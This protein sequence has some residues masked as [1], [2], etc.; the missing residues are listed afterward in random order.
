MLI[1]LS[2]LVVFMLMGVTFLVVSSQYQRGATELAKVDRLGNDPQNDLD[3]AMYQ[4]VRD[5]PVPPGPAAAVPGV[6]PSSLK[7]HSLLADLYGTYDGFQGIT[8]A[9]AV[10]DGNGQWFR[11]KFLP[12]TPPVNWPRQISVVPDAYN[13]CVI[14]FTSGPL[15]QYS[16]RI[17]KYSP[18]PVNEITVEAFEEPEL[19]ATNVLS[20]LNSQ[21]MEFVVN[22]FPFN[23]T[24]MGYKVSPQKNLSATYNSA[25][26]AQY[27]TLLPHVA[28]YT[29]PALPNLGGEDE[30]WDAVDV[31]NLHLAMVPPSTTIAGLRAFDIIP[32]FHRP[33]LVQ[34]YNRL[35]T[36]NPALMFGSPPLITG[37]DPTNPRVVNPSSFT[38]TAFEGRDLWRNV[39]LRPNQMDHPRFTGSNPAFGPLAL[40]PD[41]TQPTYMNFL[42]SIQYDVDN[43][44]DGIT[45]SVWLDLGYPAMTA[46]NGRKYKPLFAILC[47]D[48]DGRVNLN[49]AGSSGN[50]TTNQ[51]I[52]LTVAPAPRVAGGQPNAGVADVIQGEGYGEAEVQMGPHATIGSIPG[53]FTQVE[54]QSILNARYGDGGPGSGT[55][56]DD[57]PTTGVKPVNLGLGGTYTT[58]YV[59]NGANGIY[60]RPSDLHGR[61]ATLLDLAGQPLTFFSGTTAT[62]FNMSLLGYNPSPLN[63]GYNDPYELNLL[64][65]PASDATFG[66]VEL[67]RMLRWQDADALSLPSRLATLASL[68]AATPLA[69]NNRRRIT[70]RS[71][72][73]PAPNIVLPKKMN[74]GGNGGVMPSEL[75]YQRL[76]LSPTYAQIA[77]PARVAA[78]LR[79]MMPFEMRRGEKLNIN[80]LLGDGLDDPNAANQNGVIDEIGEATPA[81]YELTNTAPFVPAVAPYRQLLAR[82]LYCLAMLLKDPNFV[83]IDGDTNTD[84]RIVTARYIAQWAINVVDFRDSDVTMTPFEFDADPFNA[85]GWNEAIDGDPSTDDTTAPDRQIVWGCEQP[86]LLLTEAVAGHDRRTEDLDTEGDDDDAAGSPTSTTDP[87]NPDVDFDSRLR[88]HGFAFVEI[89]NPRNAITALPTELYQNDTN[90]NPALALNRIGPGGSP[91]WRMIVVKGDSQQKDPDNRQGA[92]PF[93]AT[94]IERSV[95][96]TATAPAAV[97]DHGVP[98]VVPTANIAPIPPGRY[99]VV[100]GYRRIEGGNSYV[101]T[102]GRH[103][104]ANDATNNVADM[105]YS[106]TRRIVLTPN[107]D[108]NA[109]NVV[110]QNNE[111]DSAAPPAPT[112][113]TIP[114]PN[115]SL[116]GVI[117]PPIAIPVTNFSV[118]EPP[119]GYPTPMPPSPVSWDPN[120]ANGEGDYTP[121]Y[122]TPLDASRSD[123]DADDQA[124]FMTDG[125]HTGYRRIF[126]QRLANPLAP[127][128][129]QSNPYLTVDSTPIDLTVFNGIEDP[130]ADDEPGMQASVDVSF[131]THERGLTTTSP[132]SRR[133][134]WRSE[135]ERNAADIVTPKDAATRN[136][137]EFRYTLKHSL[138]YLNLTYRDTT[139]PAMNP[140]VPA[141]SITFDGAPDS[142]NVGT[143]PWLTWNNRPYANHFELLQV[144]CTSSSQLMRQFTY[145]E[146]PTAG[147]SVYD[148][149]TTLPPGASDNP[150]NPKQPFRHLMNFFY[151]PPNVND[152]SPN[153]C[154][155]L[156]Y[157]EVPS[158][159]A[160]TRR[161]YAPALTTALG[162][163]NEYKF[164]FSSSSRFRIPGRVNINTIFDPVVWNSL[165]QGFPD[166]QARWEEFRESRDN[167]DIANTPYYPD[168]T[169]NPVRPASAAQLMPPVENM[170]QR[171]PSEVGLLRPLSATDETPMFARDPGGII[172]GTPTNFNDPYRNSYFRYQPL[173]RIGNMVT[174]HSN[175]YAVWITVGYFEVTS[176]SPHPTMMA[177]PVAMAAFNRQYPDGYTLGPELGLDTGTVE[178]HRAF[179]IIDRSI[180]VAFEPGRNHNVDKA[181]VLR[182]FLE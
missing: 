137:S 12:K 24:G 99:A 50:I 74:L 63:D 143:F 138:G 53:L 33:H 135:T 91:V 86:E 128:H 19:V 114:I 166:M 11:F 102:I 29:P 155:I 23:G 88:P 87:F 38:P 40:T 1:I 157:V 65:S 146:Q 160:G 156:D 27:V 68:N 39:I 129:P 45:D 28:R 49:T 140:N 148:T 179:Y 101:T 46:A 154:N 110:V 69:A 115:T 95:Y 121:P 106:E 124:V 105:K 132:I 34:Y 6:N 92:N 171:R 180:P 170:D 35:T 158:R 108:P 172:G 77:N 48:L 177:D 149:I 182:R 22:G 82:H 79:I 118:S 122:D 90:G 167:I 58:G 31:Q 32:S 60:Q 83:I 21:Q 181:V 94:D 76:A 153:F 44:G 100:G 62:P 10:V 130:G 134:L 72:D 16:T 75:F 107:V 55:A 78:Q 163:M 2:L 131:V 3:T 70:T 141:N 127:W 59:A 144:P 13:G 96:F 5:V 80:R 111:A 174:T 145:T 71:F 42:S 61:S 169:H 56:D 139:S 51:D 113:D 136:S 18:L 57:L 52:D 36:G 64:D 159:F 20:A 176:V 125:T 14:T 103:Q 25:T 173:Q 9:P 117:P 7:S 123:L 89:Y 41:P 147:A 67:E 47:I 26:S 66:L 168:F 15:A 175:V 37:F 97:T 120:G 152:D 164:P 30:P 104:S 162:Q 119:T 17:I 98:Y 151:R 8:S 109:N 161:W 178:R 85:D 54:V 165:W 84:D 142:T 81:P 4:L 112:P 93:L 116:G 126:L 133:V 150:A 73:I 43:D